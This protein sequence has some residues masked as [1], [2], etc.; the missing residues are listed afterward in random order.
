LNA[1]LNTIHT[2]V[3]V[4]GGGTWR[5]AMFQ[6]T[7][8]AFHG[9]P[10]L[11]QALTEELRD[12]ARD[13]PQADAGTPGAEAVDERRRQ[14][15]AVD[16]RQPRQ[17]ERAGAAALQRSVRARAVRRAGFELQKTMRARW[18]RRATARISISRFGPSSS[19]TRC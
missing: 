6:S 5:A 12:A 10:D 2:L 16:C 18:A 14:H 7:P 13:A 1:A 3:A 8:A 17:G 15:R 9:R 4:E 11:S 19:T